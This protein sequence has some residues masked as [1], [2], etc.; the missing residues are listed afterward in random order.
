MKQGTITKKSQR[1]NGRTIRNN[2]LLNY[3]K[4]KSNLY[5]VSNYRREPLVAG[6]LVLKF[7]EATGTAKV[8]LGDMDDCNGE[9]L[10]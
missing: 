3:T 1:F 7:L 2:S 6:Y 5:Q 10:L 4:E 9:L 8:A